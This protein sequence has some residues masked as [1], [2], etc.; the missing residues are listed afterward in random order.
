M[1]TTCVLN[2]IGIAY[3]IIENNIYK[4]F[5]KIGLRRVFCFADYIKLS[6]YICKSHKF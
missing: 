1:F 3:V 5:L 6:G 4:M 2:D